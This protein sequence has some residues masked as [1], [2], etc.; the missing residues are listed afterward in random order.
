MNDDIRSRKL[1]KAEAVI[2]SNPDIAMQVLDAMAL[3]DRTRD[4]MSRMTDEERADL[5]AF[6][7]MLPALE[8]A[9]L[10]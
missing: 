7:R 5:M 2:E 10:L 8:A 9:G 1:A 6:A 4:S 3:V